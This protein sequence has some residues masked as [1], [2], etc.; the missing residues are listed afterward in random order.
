MPTYVFCDKKEVG[1]S[2][3]GSVS[4]VKDFFFIS[5]AIAKHMWLSLIII[6][7]RSQRISSG[8]VVVNPCPA[9]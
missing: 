8:G 7:V 3:N 1:V 4:S 5:A 2:A 9:E 6:L